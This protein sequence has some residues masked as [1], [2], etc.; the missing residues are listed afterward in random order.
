MAEKYSILRKPIKRELDSGIGESLQ[1]EMKS[2]L[3]TL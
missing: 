3:R 2:K 1:E